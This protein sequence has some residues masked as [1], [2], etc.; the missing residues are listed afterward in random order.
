[1]T[2]TRRKSTTRAVA[3]NGATEPNWTRIF[4]VTV[5]IVGSALVIGAVARHRTARRVG[6]LGLAHLAERNAGRIIDV[7]QSMASRWWP[8]VSDGV[9]EVVRKPAALLGR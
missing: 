2:E 6:L 7:T 4:A 9:A 3:R 1:M 5:G 8:R